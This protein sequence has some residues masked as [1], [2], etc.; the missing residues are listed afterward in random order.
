MS[1]TFSMPDFG[2]STAS[3]APGGGLG[4]AGLVNPAFA[5]AGLGLA[6][7][8]AISA[9]KAASKARKENEKRY[10]QMLA[11]LRLQGEAAKQ[12]IAASSKNN[13]G[14]IQQSLIGRGLLNTTV[15]ND[16][17]GAE[18]SRAQR[19]TN[20]VN[21][22]TASQLAGVV[23]SRSDV[24]PDTGATNKALGESAM[25]FGGSIAKMFGPS[26]EDSYARLRA[27]TREQDQQDM[28][29]NYSTLQ[30]LMN[31]DRPPSGNP[32][33]VSIQSPTNNY[34]NVLKYIHRGRG[35]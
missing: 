19:E 32:N 5:A 12:D 1:S 11:L 4:L 9:N 27:I 21:E 20:A 33:G 24:G 15:L 6:A 3:M 14:A 29:A 10:N 22:S 17:Q 30:D 13:Q 23:G 34:A 16:L 25:N 18:A 28:T 7:Y 2:T 8:G 31:K 26:P 35:Y